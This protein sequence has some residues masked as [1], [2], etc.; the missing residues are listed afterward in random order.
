MGQGLHVAEIY[1]GAS[2]RL[3]GRLEH[4]QDLT[5]Q[6]LERFIKE[7]AAKYG[8]S[9]VPYPHVPGNFLIVEST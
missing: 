4:P 3:L 5:N 6:D 1:A 9:A 7:Q 8:L 2:K